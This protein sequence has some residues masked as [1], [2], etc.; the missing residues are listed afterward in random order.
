MQNTFEELRKY[1]EENNQ[2]F[3]VFYNCV[4]KE[5]EVNVPVRSHPTFTGRGTTLDE[6]AKFV[7]HSLQN[8]AAK[9]KK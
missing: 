3:Y 1:C 2:Q 6:A 5:Y 8:L 4:I 9:L 7:W